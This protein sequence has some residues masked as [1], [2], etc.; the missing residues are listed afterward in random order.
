MFLMCVS[1]VVRECKLNSFKFED[2]F[3]SLGGMN[4]VPYLFLIAKLERKD[5][6]LDCNFFC[7]F[8]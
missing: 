6:C 7:V 1:S 3:L 8:L 2:F 5:M 4:C